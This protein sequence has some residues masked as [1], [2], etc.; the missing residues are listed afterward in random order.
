LIKIRARLAFVGVFAIF[1]R[2]FRFD[3]F[4]V[5]DFTK[6]ERQKFLRAA[7][8]HEFSKLHLIQRIAA[9]LRHGELAH[10]VCPRHWGRPFAIVKRNFERANCTPDTFWVIAMRKAHRVAQSGLN[11]HLPR[12]RFAESRRQSVT[13]QF[14]DFAC[15]FFCGFDGQ[16][17]FHRRAVNHFQMPQSTQK[18]QK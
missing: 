8:K 3:G 14:D 17:S 15:V 10:S 9:K 18:V 7:K 12:L 13:Q 6:N 2:M 1:L 5:R 11:A 4:I 16:L